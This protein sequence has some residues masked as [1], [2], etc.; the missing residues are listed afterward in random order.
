MYLNEKKMSDIQ[1]NFHSFLK[2]L[3]I[4]GL[5]KDQAHMYQHICWQGDPPTPQ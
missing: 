4:P 1:E 2:K 5:Y 3:D